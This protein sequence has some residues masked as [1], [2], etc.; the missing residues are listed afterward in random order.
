M[1]AKVTTSGGLVLLLWIIANEAAMNGCDCDDEVNQKPLSYIFMYRKTGITFHKY[2]TTT[3]LHGWM[4]LW[5]VVV[6][7]VRVVVVFFCRLP[8]MRNVS[9]EKANC[10]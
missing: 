4:G 3:I 5:V 7:A 9:L 8:V 10:N 2:T 1:V 6:V